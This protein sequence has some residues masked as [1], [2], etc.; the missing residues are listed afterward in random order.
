MT[1]DSRSLDWLPRP[2]TWPQ[3]MPNAL[4]NGGLAPPEVPAR[5]AFDWEEGPNGGL[6]GRPSALWGRA[7]SRWWESI[8]SE[9]ATGNGGLLGS[10]SESSDSFWTDPSPPMKSPTTWA[11][12]SLPSLSALPNPTNSAPATNPGFFAPELAAVTRYP[13][14]RAF[15]LCLE[16]VPPPH[17]SCYQALKQCKDGVTTIF[18]GG[19]VGQR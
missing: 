18:P 10:L 4:W 16:V 12:E 3:W 1:D 11:P 9:S 8:P 13:C 5:I 2:Q 6:T 17:I 7:N 14:G 15:G 19:F